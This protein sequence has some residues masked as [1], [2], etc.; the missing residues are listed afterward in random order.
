MNK[1][2]IINC[3]YYVPDEIKEKITKEYILECYWR[4]I[5]HYEY[6]SNAIIVLHCTIDGVKFHAHLYDK[7]ADVSNLSC[8]ISSM[9]RLFELTENEYYYFKLKNGI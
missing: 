2:L 8:L 7:I 4:E 9:Y 3:A 5:Y 1:Q 6:K